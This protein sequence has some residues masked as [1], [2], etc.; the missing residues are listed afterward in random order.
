MPWRWTFLSRF[1]IP[2]LLNGSEV[3]VY[4]EVNREQTSAG[5][6]ALALAKA[7]FASAAELCII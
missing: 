3:Q 6:R 2:K 7:K 1:H 5:T 4:L